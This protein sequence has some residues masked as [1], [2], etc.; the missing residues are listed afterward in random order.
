YYP[1]AIFFYRFEVGQQSSRRRS[2]DESCP[3]QLSVAARCS[4]PSDNQ[5]VHP[6]VLAIV[7]GHFSAIHGAVG[8]RRSGPHA[9]GKV[10][11]GARGGRF[12]NAASVLGSAI[13]KLGRTP[14]LLP[15][16]VNYFSPGVRQPAPD[17][18]GG[19]G[20]AGHLAIDHG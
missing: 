16:E 10:C 12:G 3:V 5:P 15:P 20:R 6:V 13:T 7:G 2:P 18:V 14:Q 1:L 11:P 9:H 19:Y 17:A 8:G 4:F